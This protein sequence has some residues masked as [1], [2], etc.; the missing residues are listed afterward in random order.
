MFYQAMKI[1]IAET[2]GIGWQEQSRYVDR[3]QAITPKQIQQV[4]NKYL[5]PKTLTIARLT[6]IE[7]QAESSETAQITKTAKP[8]VK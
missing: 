4:A 8:E 3:I 5:L 2:V 6:P 7:K 1:G